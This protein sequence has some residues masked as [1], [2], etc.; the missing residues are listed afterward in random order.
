MKLIVVAAMLLR[1]VGSV[2][3]A[4]RRSAAARASIGAR[5]VATVIGL[6]A[7]LTF[8]AAPSDA[9][10]GGPTIVFEVGHADCSYGFGTT[11]ISFYVNDVLL[12][13]EPTQTAC[14]CGNGDVGRYEFSGPGVASLLGDPSC[15][16]FHVAVTHVGDGVYVGYVKVTV[17]GS[18]HDGEA[19]V[20]AQPSFDPVLTC[21]D[22]GCKAAEGPP[23]VLPTGPDHD[24]DGIASGIG[25]GCDLCV[26][27]Y[28][29][30]QPD[31][32]GDGWGDTCDRCPGQPG[33]DDPDRD[34]V[35]EPFD[36]CPFD[37][38]ADQ[39][40][41][42]GDGVGDACDRCIGATPD[43]RDND[44]DGICDGVDNCRNWF[45]DDQADADGDGF[46]DACDSCPNTASTTQSDVDFD[47]LGDACDPEVCYDKDGDG[48][49][50][51]LAPGPNGPAN[52]C[53]LDNCAFNSN[54]GQE[55]A[56]GDGSGDACDFC[57]GPGLY[58]QDEDLRCDDRDNCYFTSNPDQ[59]DAD[60]DG[61]GDACD[62]CSGR[63]DY[64][65]DGDGLCW[66]DDNCPGDPNPLQED[67]DADVVGDA[68]DS[69]LL[70]ANPV[71]PS[72]GA[73]PDADFDGIG[74]ACDPV[75]CEDSDGDGARDPFTTGD[76]AVDNCP[77]RPNPDQADADADGVGDLCDDCPAAA[78][79][80]QIDVDGDGIGDVCDP[81][82]CI[83]SDRDG[84][85]NPNA[86]GNQCALDNCPFARNP[87]LL[88]RW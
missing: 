58:D 28:D 46:G 20:F 29:P 42:D 44:G 69:C 3:A 50:N 12:G 4:S 51:P 21:R 14:T 86:P 2:L 31:A 73:Q 70:I 54:P 17:L 68:C 64:D 67:G 45:N 6:A 1:A 80:S 76:C 62:F 41:S 60:G 32:D 25:P 52:E 56:D 66:G 7:L 75:R 88:R 71:D 13:V 8:A 9:Q 83:D 22:D 23:L 47:G 40:D 33:N 81:V 18:S 39:A 49:G 5:A 65:G 79:P 26:N 77:S 48:L 30:A 27:S 74:D 35:C 59:A 63:G 37:E 85:G 19:C 24:S 11:T 38:N 57:A 43:S 72:V 15:D 87:M 16:R 78:N 84:F 61:F 53:P 36:N 55:D 34:G 82:Y 10:S